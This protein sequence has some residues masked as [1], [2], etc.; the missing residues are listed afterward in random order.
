VHLACYSAKQLE[1]AYHLRGLYARGFT[2]RGRTIVIVDPFG[3]PTIRHD[4]RV[5]DHRS[6]LPA[7]PS[8]RV[9]APVGRVPPYN[10]NDP[11]M[12]GKAAETTG[13]VELAHAFAPGADILLVETPVA[14]TDNGGGFPK[15]LAAEDYVIRHNLG[16]VISQSFSLPEENLGHRFVASLRYAYRDAFRHRVSI[17]AASNDF[18]VTGPSLP[19]GAFYKHRVVYWPASDPLVTA[20]GGTRLHL[21]AAGKR[22]SS[23]TAWNDSHSLAVSTSVGPEPWAS[24]GGLSKLFARPGYQDA[25]RR[26]VGDRRGVPDVALSAAFRGGTLAYGSFRVGSYRGTPGWF[27]GGG[28]S[29]ATPDFAGIVAIADQYAHQRLGFL[30]P[31]LYR[32]ERAHARGVVDVVK[33]NNTVT[34]ALP[35]GEQFRLKGYRAKPGYDLVTGLGTVDASR[36]VPE[37]A[38]RR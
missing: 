32:L 26:I 7:P 2:G 36:L 24:N 10:P 12:T 28:T 19:T 16:D 22:T 23:D 13:D 33:G 9:L 1:K 20:V 38:R 11:A 14:E 15:M 21:G 8:F 37:L 3:S 30:N 25:L 27:I 29:A 18:G 34:F 4:L 5:F 6:G 31:A 35:N 17:L